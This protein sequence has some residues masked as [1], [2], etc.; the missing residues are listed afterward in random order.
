MTYKSASDVSD[1][2][3]VGGLTYSG[4]Q[5][6]RMAYRKAA[7]SLSRHV[8]S[9]T[10][11][12]IQA[13]RFLSKYAAAKESHP[14]E[15]PYV[16]A[17][18]IIGGFASGASIGLGSY[19]HNQRPDLNKLNVDV[20]N[21][22]TEVDVAK[23][24]IGVANNRVSGY[25]KDLARANADLAY[26][27]SYVNNYRRRSAT[28]GLKRSIR[29]KNMAAA[30]LDSAN[31]KLKNAERN[32]ATAKNEYKYLTR[33]GTVHKL[34]G[35]AGLAASLAPSAMVYFD[36]RKA[37]KVKTAGI[38]SNLMN[39]VKGMRSRYN[40]AKATKALF[41]DNLAANLSR[42]KALTNM[43][44]SD[45]RTSSALHSAAMKRNLGKGYSYA[46]QDA[47]KM[48]SRVHT[49]VSELRNLRAEQ[50]GLESRVNEMSSPLYAFKAALGRTSRQ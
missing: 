48:R 6:K 33:K 44:D 20:H 21:A 40:A 2:L 14:L 19:Y 28:N 26:N 3:L 11:T 49:N 50:T 23:N 13:A 46:A 38:G 36:I 12:A 18:Q 39:F 43:I 9:Q 30:A 24:N 29:N 1:A 25:T 17:G 37:D 45:C 22:A 47:T 27:D 8:P 5:G 34:L 15:S 7:S 41:N 35:A 16:R 32:L 4:I 31:L 10:M 42:Q